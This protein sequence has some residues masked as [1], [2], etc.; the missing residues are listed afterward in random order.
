MAQTSRGIKYP[1]DYSA[2]A[3]IPADLQEM[4]ESIDEAIGN[5]VQE[6]TY[7]DTA[8]KARVTTVEG[9]ISDIETGQTVQNANIVALQT[10]NERL[11]AT[12]KTTTD[13]GET[14][15]LDKT[16]LMEFVKAPLPG[17]NTKQNG[18]PSPDNAFKYATSTEVKV[19]PSPVFIS[20][21]LPK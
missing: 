1:N 18:T 4:A 12:L 14:I 16:A 20:A 21:I 10:E 5:G 8:L 19:L 13:T 17:G 9:K 3:D 2:V 11:K 15:T 7:D 6:A